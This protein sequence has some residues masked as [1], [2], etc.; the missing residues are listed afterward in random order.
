MKA[1]NVMTT[2]V[3]TVN[4]LATIAQAARLMKQY[5]LR[6]LIVDR[7]NQEDAYGIITA[8]DISQAIANGKDPET[9]Y[10]R[11][12]MT[13]PCIVVNPDLAVEHIIKLFAR[14]KIH[15]A[16]VIQDRLLGVISL[17]DILTK[18]DC[19]TP[20]KINS[21]SMNRSELPE[22]PSERSL[23]KEGQIEEWERE[24]DNWCSG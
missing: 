21:I 8:T 6:D 15:T 4:S 18:T 23:T 9:T 16:P 1:A 11:E 22:L 20:D 10:V 19:L 7:T 17:T 14:A 3:V 24:Y 12:V 13:Q 2:K 5:C